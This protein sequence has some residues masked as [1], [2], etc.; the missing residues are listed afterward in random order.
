MGLFLS[1]KHPGGDL[2]K[3]LLLRCRVWAPVTWEAVG[4]AALHGD[5]WPLVDHLCSCWGKVFVTQATTPEVNAVALG[6]LVPSL[7]HLCLCL[8]YYLRYVGVSA[9]SASHQL[10]GRADV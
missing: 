1:G 3:L 8:P 5:L 7:G 6:G 4:Y 2:G 9:Q 10:S